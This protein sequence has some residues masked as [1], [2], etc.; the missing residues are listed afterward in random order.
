MNVKL[1]DESVCV[2]G[3]FPTLGYLKT[4]NIMGA[5]NITG[6]VAGTLGMAF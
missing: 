2:G 1:E 6:A 4:P 3:V 5:I